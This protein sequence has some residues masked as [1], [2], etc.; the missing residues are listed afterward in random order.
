MRLANVAIHNFRSIRHAAFEAH[1]YT[2]LVGANNAGKTAVIDALRAFYEHEKYKYKADRDA[3]RNPDPDDQASWVE[4]QFTLTE[5]EVEQLPDQYRLPGDKLKVRKWFSNAPEGREDGTIYGYEGAGELSS[6]AI[7]GAANVQ[8]GRLGK[9]IYIP[10]VSKVDDHT[11]LSG[12][13]VLRNT[14]DELLGAVISESPAYERF[15][16][17]FEAFAEE[18]RNSAAEDGRSLQQF[19]QHLTDELASWDAGFKLRFEPPNPQAITKNLIGW[20]MTDADGSAV[21]HGIEQYGSGFQRHFIASLIRTRA[22]FQTR[23][24]PARRQFSPDL[25]LILFEEPEAYLHPP[26]QAALARNLREVVSNS[27]WQVLASTH[28]PQ[29]V[30]RNTEHLGCLVRV[31]KNDNISTTHQLS[32]EDI[33]AIFS[34]RE[35]LEGIV[36]NWDQL[37][38]DQRGELERIRFFLWMDNERSS[39]FFV[40][41]VLLVEGPTES[42]LFSRMIDDGRLELPKTTCEILH[43]DGKYNAIRFMRLLAKLGMPHIVVHDADPNGGRCQEQLNELIQ[44]EA[45]N[46]EFTYDVILL[47]PDLEDYLEWPKPQRRHQGLKPGVALLNYEERGAT[48][49][50]LDELCARIVQCIPVE[51]GT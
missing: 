35:E 10:A 40:D 46:S 9:L 34:A 39:L 11:K 33:T 38:D 12:P 3:P 36:G 22:Y 8:K 31:R 28:S 7:F 19:E 1:P 17:E 21:G 25:T 18:I 49:P 30:S 32:P 27:A 43:S 13:S 23:P 50:K 47:D 4:L 14:I 45:Q 29:F 16:G 51:A 15:K 6:N 24:A 20:D 48:T 42:A 44:R 37:D 41:L 5:Q 26:Q 2:L